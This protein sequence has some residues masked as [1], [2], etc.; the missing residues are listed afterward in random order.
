MLYVN[1]I[2]LDE[3]QYI[4][5]HNPTRVILKTK[6]NPLDEVVYSDDGICFYPV[7]WIESDDCCQFNCCSECQK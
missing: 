1:S 6:T 5:Y 7:Q 4:L 3:D 2:L